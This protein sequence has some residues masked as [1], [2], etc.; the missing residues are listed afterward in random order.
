MPNP[1]LS[2]FIDIETPLADAIATLLAAQGLTVVRER[3]TDTLTT[4]R[5][6][7]TVDVGGAIEHRLVSD[8]YGVVRS[9]FEVDVSVKVVT[10]RDPAD[11]QPAQDHDA[12]VTSARRALATWR[13]DFTVANLP[14][15]RLELLTFSGETVEAN[16]EDRQDET[17]L[18]YSAVVIYRADVFA[19][20][21]QASATL[22]ANGQSA[23]LTV[24]EGT[25]IT[26]VGSA[27]GGEAGWTP[28]YWTLTVTEVQG[29][30]GQ[31]AFHAGEAGSSPHT[32]TPDYDL[33]GVGGS[34]DNGQLILDFRLVASD[35]LFETNTATDTIRVTINEA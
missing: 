4:D 3:A 31:L 11:G 10:R 26:M 5:A 14:Y 22:T 33:P 9:G 27:D 29:E 2:D 7:L 15:H 24:T 28:A 25:P 17:L 23:D 6:E 32:F 1:T 13:Q 12:D 16:E 34:F 35:D 21:G 8:I 20:A 30:A 19:T 18:S